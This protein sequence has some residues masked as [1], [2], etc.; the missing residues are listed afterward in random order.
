MW[1]LLPYICG[2][3]GIGRRTGLKIQRA[4]M[5]VRV[6]VSLPAPELKNY[7]FAFHKK[8]IPQLFVSQAQQGRKHRSGLG[9]RMKV[10]RLSKAELYLPILVGYSFDE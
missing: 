3:G 4:V 6:Q 5:H 7:L 2:Y 8:S 1:K 9:Q 10:Q